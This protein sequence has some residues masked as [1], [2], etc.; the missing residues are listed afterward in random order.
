MLVHEVWGL[1]E[2][3]EEG[4]KGRVTNRGLTSEFLQSGL[5]GAGKTGTLLLS[6]R[7]L[8]KLMGL[9]QEEL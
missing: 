4:T 7:I 9:C 1:W 6:F 2:E 3:W 5:E 8:K